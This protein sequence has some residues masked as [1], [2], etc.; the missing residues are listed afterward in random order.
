LIFIFSLKATKNT[1]ENLTRY[2]TDRFLEAVR[3][4]YRIAK[5]HYDTCYTKLIRPRLCDFLID[6]RKRQ[7]KVAK[8]GFTNNQEFDTSMD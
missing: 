8:Q 5:L 7:A 2:K 6:E 4:K 1:G 3:V